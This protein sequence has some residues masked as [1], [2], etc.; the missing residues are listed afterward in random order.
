MHGESW[1]NFFILV[2]WMFLFMYVRWTTL[3]LIPLTPRSTSR[4]CEMKYLSCVRYGRMG[5]SGHS[6]APLSIYIKNV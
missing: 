6:M 4:R 5:N 2:N 3:G 1:N